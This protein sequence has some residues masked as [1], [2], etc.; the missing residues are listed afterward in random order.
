MPPNPPLNQCLIPEG[1]AP[2]KGHECTLSLLSLGLSPFVVTPPRALF[3]SPCLRS[4]KTFTWVGFKETARCEF[5]LAC[6]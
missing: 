2:V 4:Q 1:A 3:T 5:L 6:A